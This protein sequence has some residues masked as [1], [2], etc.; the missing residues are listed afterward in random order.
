[1]GGDLTGRPETPTIN[2]NAASLKHTLLGPR[3][4]DTVTSTP[5]TGALVVGSGVS[6]T[7]LPVGTTGQVLTVGNAGALGWATGGGGGGGAPTN[8][9]YLTLASD[10]TLT[11]ERVFAHSARLAHTD[12]GAG[13][14]YT[15]DLNVSGVAAGSYTYASVTVDTYGRVTAA[16]SGSAPVAPPAPATTVVTETS[17]GQTQAVGIA[18]TYAREDHSHGTPAVPAHNTLSNLAWINA[19]HTGAA[20]AVAAWNAAGAATVVQATTDETMLVRRAG[21]LQWV[22]LVVAMS[23]L[24]GEL[25]LEGGVL[26][27]TSATVYTG[28]II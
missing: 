12:G 4:T 15:L 8:A 22:P 14:N 2:P 25:V 16:S 17:Y 28:T 24:D 21:T 1:M 19:A 20:N 13:G 6:W 9:Q 23:V 10:A 3:H 26:Y 5:A 27:G 11:D 7:K 18:T